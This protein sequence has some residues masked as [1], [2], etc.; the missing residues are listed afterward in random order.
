M[1]AAWFL[2]A[3]LREHYLLEEWGVPPSPLFSRK[4]LK[5]DYLTPKY[6]IIRT[7]GRTTSYFPPFRYFPC[8]HLVVKERF[9]GHFFGARKPVSG[10]G[11]TT[12]L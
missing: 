9:L 10:D 4:A 1:K 6:S 12:A 5:T 8:Q 7:Y 2:C 3:H 11:Q